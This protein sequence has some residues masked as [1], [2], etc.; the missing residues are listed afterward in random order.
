MVGLKK[1]A[2]MMPAKLDAD[3]WCQDA[4]GEE[5]AATAHWERMPALP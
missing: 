5:A 1:D 4:N 2:W 3:V